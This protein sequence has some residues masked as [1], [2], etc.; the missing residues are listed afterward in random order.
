[1]AITSSQCVLCFYKTRIDE[2]DYGPVR[3]FDD[4]NMKGLEVAFLKD[5]LLT[6]YDDRKKMFHKHRPLVESWVEEVEE[7]GRRRDT[8]QES[9]YRYRTAVFFWPKAMNAEILS[10]QKSDGMFTLYSKRASKTAIFEMGLQIIQL[11]ESKKCLMSTDMLHLLYKVENEDMIISALKCCESIVD[12]KFASLLARVSNS[13]TS[14]EIKVELL[15][16]VKRTSAATN[17]GKK[18]KPLH[19]SIQFLQCLREDHSFAAQVRECLILGAMGNIL[20]IVKMKLNF[21]ELKDIALETDEHTCKSF[22]CACKKAEESER[23]G[24][25]ENNW[26]HF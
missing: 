21:P 11:L 13:F 2:D 16:L 9:E 14:E 3:C 12:T 8:H 1:M 4:Q 19:M 18:Y 7:V 20:E 17:V 6:C 26:R 25:N 5:Y 10:S 22:Y 24:F 23:Q 15:N